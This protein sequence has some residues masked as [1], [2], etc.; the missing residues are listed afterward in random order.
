[1]A[2][3][4][5]NFAKMYQTVISAEDVTALHSDLSNL[6]AWSKEWQMLFND[7]KCK[8]MHMGYNNVQVEYVMY[9]V[10][11]DCVSDEKYLGVIVSDDLQ[12]GKQ[13]DK[14]MKKAN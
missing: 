5:L 4:I 11:L 7:K 10:K 12:S 13:C 14:A 6:V 8:V 2:G 9:D 1:V 3:K